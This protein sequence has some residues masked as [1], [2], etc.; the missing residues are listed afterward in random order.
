MLA[1][2]QARIFFTLN[3]PLEK[4]ILQKIAANS[5]SMRVI[6]LNQGIALHYFDSRE[7]EGHGALAEPD[8]HTW[9]DPLNATQQAAVM[10][11]ALQASAPS[12]RY[13]HNFQALAQ[14]LRQLDA[15]LQASLRPFAGQAFLV[16]HPSFGY[17]A[18]RYGLR[19]IA[20]EEEG[21]EPGP[22]RL[23]RLLEQARQLGIKIIFTQPQFPRAQAQRL[24]QAI[25]GQVLTLDP[26]A[27]DYLRAL[28]DIA[29]QL[30]KGF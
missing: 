24:A 9:L 13:E 4:R 21:K 2:S 6:D 8:P 30:R 14:R 5:P 15:N 17:L 26:L 28:S 10:A 3:M 22:R 7:E 12:P 23:A 20:L 18:R 27:Y 25:G 11:A 29:G 16:Y 1:L 19:Q